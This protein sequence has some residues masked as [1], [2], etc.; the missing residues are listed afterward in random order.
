[1]FEIRPSRKRKE[2]IYDQKQKRLYHAA[3]GGFLLQGAD[4]ESQ[5]E[6]G[7]HCRAA[8][9][10]PVEYQEDDVAADDTGQAIEG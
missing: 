6:E 3:D 1:M 8:K 7:L 5:D 4:A 2:R 10:F 9:D